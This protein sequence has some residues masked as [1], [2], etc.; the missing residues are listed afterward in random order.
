MVVIVNVMATAVTAVVCCV[1]LLSSSVVV[2]LPPNLV[3][4]QVPELVLNPVGGEM[5]VQVGVPMPKNVGAVQVIPRIGLVQ[6]STIIPP[7]NCEV[8]DGVNE[9]K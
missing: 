3:Q 5:P 1:A 2:E 6:K 9:T 7:I 4:F 8:D